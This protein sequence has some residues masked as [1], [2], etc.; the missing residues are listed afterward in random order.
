MR[1]QSSLH[2]VQRIQS[3]CNIVTNLLIRLTVRRPLVHNR[4]NHCFYLSRQFCADADTKDAAQAQ[5]EHAQSGSCVLASRDCWDVH[6][7]RAF[8]VMTE[9]SVV[10][11]PRHTT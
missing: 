8:L 4:R 2:I 1:L 11:Q 9:I 6:S 7:I 3:G 5:N 10:Q